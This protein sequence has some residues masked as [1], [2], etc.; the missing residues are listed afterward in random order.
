MA[1]KDLSYKYDSCECGTRKLKRSKYCKRCFYKRGLH[2]NSGPK[3][4][5]PNVSRVDCK[6]CGKRLPKQRKSFC[7]TE[8]RFKHCSLPERDCVCC[9]KRFKPKASKSKYCT[10]ECANKHKS[11]TYIQPNSTTQKNKT[12]VNGVPFGTTC[13]LLYSKCRCCKQQRPTLSPNAGFYC[14]KKCQ[15]HDYYEREC[16]KGKRSRKVGLSVC[17]WCGAKRYLAKHANKMFCSAKCR[18]KKMNAERRHRKRTQKYVEGISW[19]TAVKRFGWACSA[20]GVTCIRPLGSNNPI[21]ATLDHVVPLSKGGSHTWDNVQLLCRK[22]NT[23]K[24]NKDWQLFKKEA[25][26]N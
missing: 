21:E 8:C 23:T 1:K 14:S 20:C 12:T 22:C 6:Q 15:C 11:V 4:L 5:E 13:K 2:M 17:I 16:K 10:N 19:K 3:R 7:S 25:L 26:T 9:G 18:S 24:N